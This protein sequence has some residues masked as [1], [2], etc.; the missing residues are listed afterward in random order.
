MQYDKKEGH[1]QPS[2]IGSLA[3]PIGVLIYLVIE[4]RKTCLC[5]VLGLTILHPR[6]WCWWMYVSHMRCATND[7]EARRILT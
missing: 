1:D 2:N 7:E 5:V 4:P 6:R 3:A